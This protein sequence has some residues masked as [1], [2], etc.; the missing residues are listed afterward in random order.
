MLSDSDYLD[1]ALEAIEREDYDNA[2]ALLA[3]KKHFNESEINKLFIKG[4]RY[5]NQEQYQASVIIF[6]Q[7]DRLIDASCDRYFNLQRALV[8]AYDKNQQEDR[9]I[10]LCQELAVSNVPVIS[11]WGQK[12]LVQLAPEIAP[13]NI[14]NLVNNESSIEK[15]IPPYIPVKSKTLSEFKQYCQNNLLVYLKEFEKKRQQTL[16]TIIIS[17]ILCLFGTWLL[18]RT[19]L[20]FF[21]VSDITFLYFYCLPLTLS[22]WVIFCRGCLQIYGLNFKRN[23]IENIVK[24]I[25]NRFDYA[26]QLFL[27]DQRRTTVAFT[28]SQLFNPNLR[29]PDELKQEDCVY[30]TIGK[31]DIFFAEIQVQNLTRSYSEQ[32]EIQQTS[33][34]KTIFRGLFFQAKFAKQFNYRTFV[35]PNDLKNKMP[36][37]NNWR[38]EVINLEDAEFNKMFRVYGDSQIESRYILSTNLI[39]RLVDFAKKAQRKVYISFIQG[40][41]YIAIPYRHNLFEPKL[42]QSMLSF[43]PLKEYFENLQLMLSI[44]EDLN[45][46]RQIWQ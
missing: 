4:D 38:G 46:N 9:A 24:F 26:N 32:Y 25:D 16:I 34:Q 12:I 45:L 39:S 22:I 7:L 44:V 5:F 35:I 23:I 37:I 21:F 41:V 27:E 14:N 1:R 17:G 29:E 18:L 11:L 3:D 10:A 20:I 15:N 43:A 33:H 42:F 31:T 19:L 36:L 30:G 2:I 40:Y 28:H 8:K 6:E 13:P